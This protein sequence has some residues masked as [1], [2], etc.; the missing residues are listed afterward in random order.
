MLLAHLQPLTLIFLSL[1]VAV[2]EVIQVLAVE[3]VASAHR[4]ELQAVAVQQNLKL[5]LLNLQVTQ[6]K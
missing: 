1:L 2:A 5:L 6:F 3:Q 4:M